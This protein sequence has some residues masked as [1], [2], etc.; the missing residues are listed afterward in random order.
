[1]RTYVAKDE[2]GDVPTVLFDSI[3]ELCEASEA[4]FHKGDWGD[5]F[6]GLLTHGKAIEMAKLGWEAELPETLALVESAVTTVE[7]EYD[8][9]TFH[10]EYGVSGQV[11]DIARYCSNEPENM[12]EFPLAVMPK[13]GRVITLCCSTSYSAAVSGKT[14]ERRG[15]VL[16]AFA[17]ALSHMGLG[18]EIYT[19]NTSQASMFGGHKDKRSCIRTKI[20]GT[21]DELDPARLMFCLAN[22]SYLR[23]VVFGAAPSAPN[24]DRF[25][26]KYY[27]S[28]KPATPVKDLPEGTIYTDEVLSGRDV[29]D[30]HASL[31][32]L[33]KEAGIVLEDKAH[34]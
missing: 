5:G 17:L 32:K 11:V 22:Q 28:S 30:A 12:M 10:T 34:A 23:R 26:G 9:T 3:E 14:I 24:F 7:Q 13:A 33:L 1:M 6:S 15:Q 16:V 27:W 20:K 29:P 21:N 8:M 18:C 4:G 25:G 19:D 2:D 31:L